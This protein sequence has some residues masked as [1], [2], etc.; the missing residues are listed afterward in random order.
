MLRTRVI[1]CLLM[2][3]GGLVK[4]VRFAAPKYV[5]D[6]INAVR[7][8]N[9]KEVDEVAFLDIGATPSNSGPDFDLLSDIASEAFMPFAYGGGITSI[10]QVKR[11]YGLGVEK[12]ILNTIAASSPELVE[13][14]AM[15][16]GSSGVVV[17]VD[18]RR[19]W[20]G[21]YG[22]YVHCGT[23][24]TGR[25]PVSY[26]RD[27]ERAGAGEILLTAIDRDGVMGGYD[28][29][30][31][32]QVT[33]AVSVPV[34]GAGGAGELRHFRD[35]VDHGAAGVAAGSMFVFHGKHRAVLITYPTYGELEELFR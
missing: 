27:M 32:Q 8:F 11:L 2:S 7:I 4:T 26:A 9:D 20:R 19:N 22:V 14:A 5:G 29:E 30:L 28:L 34:I 21:K 25:D 15:A 18:V 31:I 16:A 3:N 35:A 17:S 10:E 12:V 6:P 23:R 1:P 13:K 24:D 33:Q